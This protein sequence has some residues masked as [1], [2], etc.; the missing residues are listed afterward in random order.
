M[1]WSVLPHPSTDSKPLALLRRFDFLSTSHHH[2]MGVG[3][4]LQ[5]K[6]PQKSPHNAHLT[7]RGSHVFPLAHKALHEPVISQPDLS[8][9]SHHVQIRE[10]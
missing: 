6:S 3:G 1:L 4:H 10:L 7:Q 9:F 2:K 5:Q 8:V